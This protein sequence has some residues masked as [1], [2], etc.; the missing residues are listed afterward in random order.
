ML[1]EAK[2]V[3]KIIFLTGVGISALAGAFRGRKDQEEDPLREI[4]EQFSDLMQKARNVHRGGGD[5]I[6]TIS[7]PRSEFL[8]KKSFREKVEPGML[9]PEMFLISRP[10]NFSDEEFNKTDNLKIMSVKKMTIRNSTGGSPLDVF[11]VE[12]VRE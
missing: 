2:D 4:K 8:V 5:Q 9:I 10:E 6:E 3:A 7:I 11:F 12:E 1:S